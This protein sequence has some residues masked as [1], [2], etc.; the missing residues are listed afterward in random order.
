MLFN[1]YSHEGGITK[2]HCRNADKKICDLLLRHLA[3]FHKCATKTRQ[4]CHQVA[5]T[6]TSFDRAMFHQTSLALLK[7][8]LLDPKVIPVISILDLFRVLMYSIS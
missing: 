8:L 6:A 1:A 7:L 2:P 4:V 5:A 3:M